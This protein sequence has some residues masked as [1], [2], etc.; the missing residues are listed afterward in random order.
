MFRFVLH[1]Y[2]CAALSIIYRC[3]DMRNAFYVKVQIKFERLPSGSLAITVVLRSTPLFLSSEKNSQ[4]ALNNTCICLY[5][6]LICST[7][8]WYYRYSMCVCRV[9]SDKTRNWILSSRLVT[10]R[11]VIVYG[12]TGIG[13]FFHLRSITLLRHHVF[14]GEI[15]SGQHCCQY[16]ALYA[17]RTNRTRNNWEITVRLLAVIWCDLVFAIAFVD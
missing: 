3:F 1:L 16:R 4:V 12:C 14:A 13:R 7:A 11:I 9:G 15:S 6:Q 10:F 8:H 17:K 5:A 2:A